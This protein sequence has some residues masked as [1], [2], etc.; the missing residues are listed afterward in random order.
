MTRVQNKTKQVAEKKL[1]FQ[2][3]IQ[4]LVKIIPRT[5]IP[6]FK[7]K[8]ELDKLIQAQ[9]PKQEWVNLKNKR[10]SFFTDRRQNYVW[11]LLNL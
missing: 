3:F 9:N 1:E 7:I 5:F 10:T 8:L 6:S 11:C 4:K 2:G